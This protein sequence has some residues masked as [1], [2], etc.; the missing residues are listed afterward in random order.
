[1]EDRVGRPP[2]AFSLQPQLLNQNGEHAFDFYSLLRQ[3]FVVLRLDQFQISSQQ[4]LIFQ[5]AGRAL[6]KCRSEPIP[7]PSLPQLW[8]DCVL[9][10][11]ATQAAPPA[12]TNGA[13]WNTLHIG[14]YRGRQFWLKVTLSTMAS[15]VDRHAT[16][17]IASFPTAS[18]PPALCPPPAMSPFS[19]R[20]HHYARLM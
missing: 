7:S 4:E 10:I 6:A 9:R 5:F 18:Q 15:G 20:R 14:W 2:S 8:G 16:R 1:M 13:T 12:I 11:S 3:C 17:I 19:Q